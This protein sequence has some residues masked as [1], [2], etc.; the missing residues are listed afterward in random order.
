MEEH[1]SFGDTALHWC[2]KKGHTDVARL[3]INVYNASQE[4]VNL[5]K[6]T[7]LHVA[8]EAGHK[9]MVKFLLESDSVEVPLVALDGKGDTALT[10]SQKG[11]NV[12]INKMV[13]KRLSMFTDELGPILDN[14]NFGGLGDPG[15][16]PDVLLPISRG[17]S[18]GGSRNGTRIN[19]DLMMQDSSRGDSRGTN[20]GGGG[21]GDPLNPRGEYRGSI[22]RGSSR[23]ESR[24]SR[25]ASRGS[26]GVTFRQVCL[27]ITTLNPFDHPLINTVTIYKILTYSLDFI[28]ILSRLYHH[29][30]PGLMIVSS[31]LTSLWVMRSTMKL[32]RNRVMMRQ[33]T[34]LG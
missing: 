11:N 14:F 17:G 5:N 18:R 25:G 26:A 27:H 9:A 32:S 29:K 24:G 6:C 8:V 31:H 1:N 2:A 28:T 4:C 13:V 15:P 16:G 7:P 23:G 33:P 22:L 30:F 19:R 20:K 3:L 12:D 10:L 21:G 34:E